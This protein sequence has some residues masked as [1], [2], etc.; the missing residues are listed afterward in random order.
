MRFSILA[1]KFAVLAASVAIGTQI[2]AAPVVYGTYYEES[3]VPFSC[4]AASSCVMWFSQL[5]TNKVT[6][7]RK[8]HCRFITTKPVLSVSLNVSQSSNGGTLRS[9]PLPLPSAPQVD[10]SQIWGSIDADTRWL[11]GAGRYPS[12]FLDTTL[13]SDTTIVCTLIGELADPI[14]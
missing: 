6:T 10:G 4:S 5:P 3:P 2:E 14:P 9:I 13:I 7:I 8:V 12:V 11:L 1:L